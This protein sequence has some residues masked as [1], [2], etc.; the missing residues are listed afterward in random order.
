MSGSD[1]FRTH[2]SAATIQQPVTFNRT[3]LYT[4][5]VWIPSYV[6]PSSLVGLATNPSGCQKVG[7][8]AHSNFEVA[9]SST[10]SRAHEQGSS[11]SIAQHQ[12]N[13]LQ[14]KIAA[15]EATLRAPSN[16]R[17]TSPVYYKNLVTLLLALSSSY[18]S[19]LVAQFTRYFPREKLNGQHYF[20]WFQSIKL[21]LEGCN[22]FGFLTGKIPRPTPGDPQEQYWKEEDSLIRSTLINIMEPQIGK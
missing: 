11:P 7:N 6:P 13:I 17:L 19:N 21:T 14:Q 10:Q 20:S 5:P 22:K 8:P 3:A 16:N 4:S 12:L 15:I 1:V 9:K 2:Q 18:V